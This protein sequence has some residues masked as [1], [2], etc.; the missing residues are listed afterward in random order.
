MCSEKLEYIR[1]WLIDNLFRSC[2]I[3]YNS[4]IREASI[5]KYDG[6]DIM[7]VIAYLYN[8]L[9]ELVHGERY[10]YFF[11][12]A[13]LIGWDCRDVLDIDDTIFE[14]GGGEWNDV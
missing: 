9:H 10:N 13:N 1:N 8:C 4:N 7:E 12:Y 5:N 6:C 11:H 14:K 3:M 2:D